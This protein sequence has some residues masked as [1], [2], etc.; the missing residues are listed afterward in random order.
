[1]VALVKYNND[2]CGLKCNCVK[3]LTVAL[4]KMIKELIFQLISGEVGQIKFEK[5][6]KCIP[7]GNTPISNGIK[8]IT[9]CAR[10]RGK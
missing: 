9:N 5:F 10:M 1:M 6:A 3:R 7:I 2:C 8:A 4:N